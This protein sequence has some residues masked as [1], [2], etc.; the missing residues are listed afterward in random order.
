M[1]TFTNHKKNVYTR[2]LFENL[3]KNM[4]CYVNIFLQ[5]FLGESK[6]EEAASHPDFVIFSEFAK[7]LNEKIDTHF[8]PEDYTPYGMKQIKTL[9][10]YFDIESEIVVSSETS[11]PY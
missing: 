11:T 7:I 6:Q 8:K 10:N 3:I 4:N 5:E 2:Y 1:E 9:F